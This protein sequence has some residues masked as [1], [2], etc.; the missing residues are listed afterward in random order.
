[1]GFYYYSDK[2][3]K[4]KKKVKIFFIHCPY[5]KYNLLNIKVQKFT[6]LYLGGQ[7]HSIITWIK[8]ITT[9]I[10]IEIKNS[11]EWVNTVF[12]LSSKP[13]IDVAF[14]QLLNG[15]SSNASLPSIPMAKIWM[16]WKIAMIR[17]LVTRNLLMV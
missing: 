15:L 1:M 5:L 10:Q 2:K 12:R 17:V 4:V 8:P 9:K 16:V 14:K 11:V 6:F 3:S 13:D 7:K